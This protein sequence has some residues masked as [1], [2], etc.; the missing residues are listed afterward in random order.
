MTWIFKLQFP[1]SPEEQE[2]KIA[3]FFFHFNEQ[4]T[5]EVS[6]ERR[7]CDLSKGIL[8]VR[9]FGLNANDVRLIFELLNPSINADKSFRKENQESPAK[10]RRRLEEVQDKEAFVS[11]LCSKFNADKSFRGENQEVQDK[12]AFISKLCS[13]FK[14]FH[15]DFS[16]NY[17]IGDDGMKYLHLMPTMIRSIDLSGCYLSTVGVAQICNFLETNKTV[18]KM[19][20]YG[21]N[22]PYLLGVEGASHVGKMLAKNTVLTEFRISAQFAIGKNGIKHLE[23]GLQ[24]NKTLKKFGNLFQMDNESL[25]CIADALM[26]LGA[27]SSLEY[28]SIRI[29]MANVRRD[30]DRE[31]V[32]SRW[33]T[34]A[35][36]CQFVKNL[37]IG[38]D[39]LA[40]EGVDSDG[41]ANIAYWLELNDLQ[42]RK[43]TREG[44]VND[45]V[46]TLEKA[47]MKKQEDS[48]FY[49]LSSNTRYLV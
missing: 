39:D 1:T 40:Y 13:K 25:S 32:F 37:G 27:E 38:Y 34:V 30:S 16:G 9:H 45:F 5:M 15:V 33:K 17:S 20:L 29:G 14:L 36:H 3:N 26:R 43:V 35:K 28:F 18:T 48:I 12:E 41:W 10:K 4:G 23:H 21:N 44:N 6:S 8:N 7:E 22:L 2:Q 42:A 47:S 31:E 24:Q 19:I 11:K 49:L 46:F